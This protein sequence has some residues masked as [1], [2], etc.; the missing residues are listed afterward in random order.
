MRASLRMDLVAALV[1]ALCAIG[2]GLR[3]PS[4][5]E[6]VKKIRTTDDLPAIPPPRQLQAMS[7]GYR[8]AGADLLWAS[9]LVEH[10]IRF[11][12]R[13]PFPGLTRYLDAVL[14]LEPEHQALFEFVDTLIVYPPGVVATAADARTARAYLER[15]TKARP[16]D[17]DVWLRYG[18]FVAFLGPS[19][20]EDEAEIEAWRK[21]GALALARAVE[22][23]SDPDRS[24]TAAT[25]LNKA[26]ER[27]AM[28]ELLQRTYARTDN[29]DTRHQI[30]LRLASIDHA[31]VEA[32]SMV[33]YFEHEW[34]SRYPFLSREA[35]LLIGPHRSPT[36]CAGPS[37][38]ALRQCPR[39]WS[40]VTD[41]WL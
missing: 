25:L 2:I 28:I 22:L 21:D 1:A 5:A 19:F 30:A 13:R 36:D 32:E 14:A 38:Y 29:P 35:A 9:L 7:L 10:G 41:D 37:S 4:L 6:S 12:E 24:I 20:L 16:Y 31:T 33:G 40:A 39:S 8:S 34:R 11:Q 3:Q 26:G 17:H 27:K 18:Q 15:G 23:G